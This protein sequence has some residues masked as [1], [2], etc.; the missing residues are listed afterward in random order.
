MD[1]IK[2]TRKNLT[3]VL[4]VI[5]SIK[6]DLIFEFFCPSGKFLGFIIAFSKTKQF[7]PTSAGQ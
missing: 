3:S 2:A 5:L 7:H 4:V 1:I 6:I